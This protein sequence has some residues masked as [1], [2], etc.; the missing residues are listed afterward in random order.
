MHSECMDFS[1]EHIIIIRC[2][3]LTEFPLLYMQCM[4]RAHT[5]YHVHIALCTRLIFICSWTV[6]YFCHVK[7]FYYNICLVDCVHKWK[8]FGNVSAQTW[9]HVHMLIVGLIC[10]LRCINIFILA[11]IK[12]PQSEYANLATTHSINVVFLTFLAHLILSNIYRQY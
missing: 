3:F 1:T 7:L 8:T 11:A 4:I 6:C 10:P 5:R 9:C 12:L 2:Q